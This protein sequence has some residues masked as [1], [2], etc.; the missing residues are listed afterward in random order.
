MKTVASAPSD[1]RGPLIV[2]DTDCVLCSGFVAFLLRHERDRSLQFVG[3]WSD[4]G[5]TLAQQHGFSRS[6]LNETFLVIVDGRAL[7]KS[8]AG[9]EILRH[10]STLAVVQRLPRHSK[11]ATGSALQFRRAVT[12]SMVRSAQGLHGGATERASSLH[13]S[14]R[15][16]LNLSALA[17][18]RSAVGRPWAGARTSGP[19]SP[20][21]QPTSAKSAG[22][23]SQA[24]A[25]SPKFRTPD[26][27]RPAARLQTG[28]R[29]SAATAVRLRTAMGGR[30]KGPRTI[31]DRA[32]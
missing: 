24:Q 3:A 13:W 7:D 22:A 15:W 6:D 1:V 21:S 12:L 19:E 20:M 9:F 28:R 26:R 30:P 27:Y 23:W 31:A 11:T 25:P 2:F 14:P 32:A 16:G 8:S 18:S 10:P 17:D 5:F 4:E 29:H